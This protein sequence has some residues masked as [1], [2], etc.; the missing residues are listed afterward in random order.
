MLFRWPNRNL[1]DNHI[2]DRQWGNRGQALSGP[3]R[4]QRGVD[5]PAITLLH[6]HLDDLEFGKVAGSDA[7]GFGMFKL[8]ADNGFVGPGESVVVFL[9]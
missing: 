6:P 5:K 4:S 2:Y 7:Q 3:R 1:F 8:P 9:N